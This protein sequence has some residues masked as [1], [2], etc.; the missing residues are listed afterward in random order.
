LIDVDE[1]PNS[2]ILAGTL[3]SG[4]VRDHLRK[5][6]MQEKARMGTSWFP[7]FLMVRILTVTEFG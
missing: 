5:P 4:C 7:A 3:S 6:G 1:S 2:I